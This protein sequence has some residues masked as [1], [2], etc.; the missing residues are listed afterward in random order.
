[1]DATLL[2]RKKE[3]MDLHLKNREM[4]VKLQKK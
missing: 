2:K 3:L 1:M 4:S